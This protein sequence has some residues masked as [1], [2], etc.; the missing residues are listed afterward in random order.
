MQFVDRLI[1]AVDDLV[2]IRQWAT[3]I[4]VPNAESLGAP[5]LTADPA[6][7]SWTAEIG[8]VSEDSTMALG[9]RQLT[10]HQL[11][12]LVK[13]SMRLLRLVPDSE[14]LVRNRLAYKFGITHEKVFLT[15]SGAQQPLGVFTASADGI[16]TS[17]ECEY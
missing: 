2:Y 8:T 5:V 12:K 9:R 10:P 1:K 17:R 7:A 16:S 4:A 13:I 3:V 15:G 6:D 11:T 14:S